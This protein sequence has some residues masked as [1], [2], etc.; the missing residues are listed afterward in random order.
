[1]TARIRFAKYGVIKFIGHLDV[2]RYFQKVVRRST[3]PVC[4]SQGYSPHQLMSFAQPLSVGVT[5]DGEYMEI[6]FDDEKTMIMARD[7]GKSP[8]QYIS[9]ELK[10]NMT[11]GF[12]I[13]A[14]HILP[15]PKPNTRQESAMSLV[16]AADY[17][18]SVKDGYNIGPDS[19]AAFNAAMEDFLAQ[20]EIT[21]TKATKKQE[22]TINI[23]EFCYPCSEFD[24]LGAKH[25][26][27][28]ENGMKYRIRLA[29]GSQMNLKP[30][31]VVSAFMQY[32]GR[33]Y[34]ENAF[35]YHRMEMYKAVQDGFLSLLG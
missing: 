25:A 1:M 21:V 2:M 10:D 15:P 35:Q 12:E 22:K 29:A 4:Y 30:D 13:I 11:E 7:R 8:E 6:E 23:K 20:E 16:A 17:Q 14:I 28:Y 31:L 9:N 24:E 26:E 18:I 3:L 33:E 27:A 32:L 5:S 19:P 34:N